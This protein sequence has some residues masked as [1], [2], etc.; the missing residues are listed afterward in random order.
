MNFFFDI[1]TFQTPFLSKQRNAVILIWYV[2]GFAFI[3][4]VTGFAFDTSHRLADYTNELME[5]I[6]QWR[7]NQI[8]A[9]WNS[10]FVAQNRGE[11]PAC[12]SKPLTYLTMLRLVVL[13]AVA[14]S[15]T[16]VFVAPLGGVEHTRATPRVALHA[17]ETSDRDTKHGNTNQPMMAILVGLALGDLAA[18]KLRI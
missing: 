1:Q 3:W 4:Y 9:R 8:L 6:L 12:L 2:T 5:V 16:S 14:A 17:K 10:R 18:L 13:C 7:S 11:N 15:L